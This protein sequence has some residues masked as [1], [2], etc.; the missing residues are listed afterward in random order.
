MDTMKCLRNIEK[1]L[2]NAN[3]LPD[4]PFKQKGEIALFPALDEDLVPE[5]LYAALFKANF[6]VGNKSFIARAA[7]DIEGADIAIIHQN[8]LNWDSFES[9]QALPFVYEG[10]YMTGERLNWLGIYHTDDY[11]ML[12]GNETFIQLVTTYLYGDND[13]ASRFKC[14]FE[15]DRMNMY[16]EDY[17]SL[18]KRWLEE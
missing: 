18:K 12:G 13:W 15:N 10:F 9:F 4:N 8:D 17:E 5:K 16:K 6:V 14:A 11:I 3:L 7:L 1:K 2:G